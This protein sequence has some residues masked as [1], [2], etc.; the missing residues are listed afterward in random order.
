MK[1][2]RLE[3]AAFAVILLVAIALRAPK[4]ADRPMHCDEAV[5]AMKFRALLERDYY[6]YDPFEYHGPTL[7]YFTLPVAFIAGQNRITEVTETT[8]RI[9]PVLFGV[10]LIASYGLLRRGMGWPVTLTAMILTAV[11]ASLVY[12]SRYYIQEMLLACFT[13]AVAACGYRYI[14]GRKIGWALAVGVLAGLVHA[15][16]ETGLIA[17]ATIIAAALIDRLSLIPTTQ[18][19]VPPPVRIPPLKRLNPWHV[20]AAVGMGI[21]ISGLFFSSFFAHP[22]GIWDSFFSYAAYVERAGHNTLHQHPWHYYLNLLFFFRF[23]DGPVWSEAMI[24]IFA[25]AGFVLAFKPGGVAGVDPR[26]HRFLALYTLMMTAFYSGIRYKTPWCAI[27]FFQPMILLAAIAMVHLVRL[28]R[29][30]FLRTAVLT[31]LVAGTSHLALQACRAAFVYPAD[32][33][34]PWVYAHTSPDI[35]DM[36]SRIRQVARVQDGPQT[37]VQIIAPND[38]YWP[39]PWYLRDFNRVSYQNHIDPA[40]PA[41][42]LLV[43]SPTLESNL[44]KL[45]YESPPPGQRRLYVPLFDDYRELRPTIELRGFVTNELWEKFQQSP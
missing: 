2:L 9:V 35:F 27:N 23:G 33:R 4:L 10:L 36:V 44:V 7:N 13:F 17:L 32:P 8:L 42:P 3:N 30:R 28:C 34:N 16:K 18:R 12:Y 31:V 15:T 19:A 6:R 20:A 1:H 45:L 43:I 38:D 11:S 41:A 37:F 29:P 21:L 39:F 40:L 22:R 14:N 26:L 24:M 5:H 25:L